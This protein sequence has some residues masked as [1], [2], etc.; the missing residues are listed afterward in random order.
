MDAEDEYRITTPSLIQPMS[1]QQSLLDE[2]CDLSM[3]TQ[4]SLLD[5]ECD[6]SMS[7]Q[8]S[9]LDEAAW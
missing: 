9:L 2:E 7:T 8:Q 1:T 3:S 4:Q 5:E 6:L